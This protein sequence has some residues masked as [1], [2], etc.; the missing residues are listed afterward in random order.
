MGTP[1]RQ[2]RRSRTGVK[3]TDLQTAGGADVETK[4]KMVATAHAWNGDIGGRLERTPGKASHKFTKQL[5][6]LVANVGETGM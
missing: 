2:S 6:R 5:G 4:P 3:T 1:S